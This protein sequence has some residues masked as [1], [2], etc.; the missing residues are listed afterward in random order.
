MSFKKSGY[1]AA[2]KRSAEI[3]ANAVRGAT[4]LVARNERPIAD[5]SEAAAS[6][7]GSGLRTGGEGLRQSGAK[8]G[9]VLHDKAKAAGM[10]VEQLVAGNTEAGAGRKA[11]AKFAGAATRVAARATGVAA[12]VAGQTGKLMLATGRLA[13]RTAPAI[14]GTVG[15]AIKGVA[16]MASDTVDAVILPTSSLDDMRLKLKRYGRSFAAG[17]G[18]RLAA[19]EAARQ[20]K[21]KGRMLDLLVIG[22]LSLADVLKSPASVPAEVEQAYRLA[23]PDMALRESFADA[24]TRMSPDQLLGLTSAVKG[25][26]FELQLVD[27][28]NQ[29]GLPAGYQ[30]EL[31]GSAV[32]PGWDIRIIDES[33]RVS[34]LLQA[35]ATESVQYVQDALQRYPGIDVTTTKEV[36]AQLTALGLAEDVHDSGISEAVLQTQVEVAATQVDAVF[37]PS[38]FVPSSI[39]L[40]VVALSV[41][42]NKDSSL[43]EQGDHFGQRAARVGVS[44]GISKAALVAT[45]TWWI[46]L[47]GGVGT[48]WLAGKGQHKRAQYEVL[49]N[50]LDVLRNPQPTRS[51]PALRLGFER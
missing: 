3:A 17:S 36:H 40:A 25:K 13:E 33:G 46:A 27:H 8:L 48:N 7:V 45:Q 24:V 38:D 34:E 19:I 21:K 44:A 15:G 43:R 2:A 16:D 12:Q 41:F 30:A 29:D 37:D 18:R 47:L 35:K 9:R 11:V 23:Y 10:V 28:L 22:G 51:V 50:A 39:G 1:A 42:M 14:G 32:Q 6:L 26:L 4:N 5:L 49:R 20:Q 31:A